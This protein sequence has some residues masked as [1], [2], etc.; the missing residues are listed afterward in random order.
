MKKD[1]RQLSVPIALLVFSGLTLLCAVG[2]LTGRITVFE[3][4]SLGSMIAM[5]VV[6][7]VSAALAI[8]NL[9]LA[10]RNSRQW[11][12]SVRAAE[13]TDALTGINNRFG[14]FT[15]GAE[16]LKNADGASY[17]AVDVDIDHF[18]NLNILYGYDRGDAVL[19]E[20]AKCIRDACGPDETCGRLD[21]DHFALLWKYRTPSEMQGRLDTL[22]K[23]IKATLV[24]SLH[25]CIGVYVLESNREA[26]E[27]V[28]DCACAARVSIKNDATRSIAQYDY[29]LHQQEIAANE[30]IDSMDTALDNKEF[31]A[32]YQPIYDIEKQH[33]VA[34]EA[35]VRWIDRDG[36]FMPPDK[37]IHLF[38]NNG[39]IIQLDYYVLEEV[40]RMQ[41]NLLR[42]GHNPV[43]IA[44]NFSRAHLY[45]RDFA[46]TVS[47]IL[48]KYSVAHWMID[49]ELTESLMT[50]DQDLT[51]ETVARLNAAGYAVSM[52]DFGSGSSSLNM[53]KDVQV[54][55]VKL[56]REFLNRCET[57][58]RGRTI[59]RGILRVAQQLQLKTVA[60]GVE[61]EEQLEFLRESGCDMAQGFLFARP[62]PGEKYIDLISDAQSPA[63][64]VKKPR[65]TR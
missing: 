30:M 58:A 63:H 50:T 37:F 25:V 48:D 12:T 19:K 23:K 18:T 59:V 44:V 45:E 8:D 9:V 42:M 29:K 7:V 32:Y 55:K 65:A 47:A 41:N 54:D 61:T 62:M 34:A 51:I 13:K 36:R 11:A 3:G 57:D 20:L 1:T 60:E 49:V 27:Y 17:M 39:L 16:L 46:D 31:C 5:I 4:R 14:L 35:L 2:A 26:M 33:I 53:L 43:P 56:D 64:S 40:C 10:V 15:E 22:L 38:E 6:S 21:G 52:D 24:H 28:T